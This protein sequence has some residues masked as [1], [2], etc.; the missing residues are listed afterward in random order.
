MKSVNFV[1]DSGSPNSAEW[2]AWRAA[3]I[4]ASDAPVIAAGIGLCEPASWMSSVHKLWLLK[5]GQSEGPKYNAAMRRGTNGEGPARIAVEKKTGLFVSPIFG[6]MDDS[7]VLRASF[8]GMDFLGSTL[9]EIKCP[10]QKVHEL[11]KDGE[12]V[13]YYVPQ[14]VHQSLV[15]WG[16]PGKWWDNKLAIFASFVPE[17]GDLALVHKTGR[18][19][20]KEF[21]VELLYKSELDFWS[22]VTTGKPACGDEFLAKA[23]VF[24]EVNARFELVEAERDAAR[25]ELVLL[26][27]EK[28]RLDGEDVSVFKVEAK[29]STDW[30]KI[31][32]KLAGDH[33]VSAEDLELLVN[34]NKK[35]GR[36]SVNVTV[37]KQKTKNTLH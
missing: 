36:K 16:L 34:G 13:G 25:A 30:E 27:G 3:G 2:H 31:A 4:G 21:D 20:Y 17:T 22:T 24:K 7:P 1:T 35:K 6:E 18:E 11:A 12:I 29:G 8:D 15:A 37:G 28:L 14:L 9:V 26:L 5:T 32:K 23:R 10:N 33:K 19:L